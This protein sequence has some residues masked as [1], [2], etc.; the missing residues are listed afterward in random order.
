ME[1]NGV[2]LNVLSYSYT[3]LEHLD[4]F[5]LVLIQGKLAQKILH[6]HL[7][8]LSVLHLLFSF[9]GLMV[10]LWVSEEGIGTEEGIVR[11]VRVVG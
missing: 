3:F 9:L 6:T 2:V 10:A 4:D 11:L 1:N 7:D 8:L 5:L